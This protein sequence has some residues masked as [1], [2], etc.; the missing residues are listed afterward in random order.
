MGVEAAKKP[1]AYL[2]SSPDKDINVESVGNKGMRLREMT[3]LGMP[4]PAGFTIITDA[5]R[6]FLKNGKL[7]RELIRELQ[8]YVRM[9]EIETKTK[10]GDPKDPLIVSVRSGAAVSMPG[11]MET[12][13]NVGLNPEI[14]SKMASRHTPRFAY[15]TYF[16]FLEMFADVVMRIEKNALQQI[17]SATRTLM[18]GQSLGSRKLRAIVQKFRKTIENKSKIIIPDDP[19]EQ[20]WLCVWAVCDSWNTARAYA[21]REQA[22]IPHTLGT[23][24]TVQKMVFGNLDNQSGSGVVFSRNTAT[25]YPSMT[26]EIIMN[27]QGEDIVSGGATPHPIAMLWRRQPDTYRQLKAIVAKLE[28][29]YRDVMEIEF[30]IEHGALHLLQARSA[31]L[32][33]HAAARIGVDMVKAHVWSQDEALTRLNGF[34]SILNPPSQLNTGQLETASKKGKV[35]QGIPASPGAVSGRIALT[36][37]Y[38][39]KHAKTDGPIIL[40]RSMTDP[41][42]FPGMQVAAAIVTAQGGA[43]SHAAVNARARGIPAIVGTHGLA[44]TESSLVFMHDGTTLGNGSWISIDGS[45]GLIAQGKMDVVKNKQPTYVRT[46]LSWLETSNPP[47]K[48]RLDFELASNGTSPHV[49]RLATD[50]YLLERMASQ[51]RLSPH[52]LRKKLEAYRF[53]FQEETATLLA[54]Y[55]ILAV[56]GELRHARAN[57][58]DPEIKLSKKNRQT[59]AGLFKKY[60]IQKDSRNGTQEA[61]AHILCEKPLSE[62]EDFLRTAA[63]LFE[64]GEWPAS[65]GDKPWAR[66]ARTVEKYL[67]GKMERTQF[68]DRCFNLQHNNGA[69]FDKRNMI[70][71]CNECLQRVLDTKRVAKSLTS[72]LFE[73]FDNH[74]RPSA[75]V[76]ALY[77]EI[78][79]A[80][81]LK[82]SPSQAA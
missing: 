6:S 70:R 81:L 80:G 29:T 60:G 1:L 4:V 75:A 55:F 72:L 79:A 42:D 3:Q 51:L 28:I 44:I 58:D 27:V 37:S 24:I 30:T 14:V 53:S 78:S 34:T 50:F 26:G 15:D 18:T 19:W 38:A 7:P 46:V 59:L 71:F 56:A 43:S 68:I 49:S 67:A 73:G 20:L 9:L 76:R 16:R 63:L 45:S 10:L 2:F 61:V 31:A 39:I 41:D 64:Q 65:Y 82:Q 62:A 35:A 69:A 13:L 48:P 5:C 21:Y 12:I 66:I 77:D 25:G 22:H 23:A 52:P 74:S 40:C 32:A 33:P 8:R 17:T 54:T 57:D 11:M 47:E 36:T